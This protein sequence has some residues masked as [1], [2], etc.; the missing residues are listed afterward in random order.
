MKI[1]G[2]PV[3]NKNLGTAAVSVY[4]C[5]I[6]LGLIGVFWTWMN[7]GDFPRLEWWQLVLA[8]F[9][10]G[11]VAIILEAAGIFFWVVLRLKNQYPK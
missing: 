5:G 4:V 10:I 1:G 9:G 3:S 11:A 2:F 6:I 7:G 8:P